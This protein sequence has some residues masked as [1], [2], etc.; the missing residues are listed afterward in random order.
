[1]IVE[2]GYLEFNASLNWQLKEIVQRWCDMISLLI[3]QYNANSIVLS[4]SE[5][6]EQAAREIKEWRVTIVKPKQSK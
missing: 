4:F 6:T 5:L 2:H 3:V 1:M